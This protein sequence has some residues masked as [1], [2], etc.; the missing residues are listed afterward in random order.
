MRQKRYKT[1]ISWDLVTTSQSPDVPVFLPPAS[2]R[3]NDTEHDVTDIPQVP[4]L[5]LTS[6]KEDLLSEHASN[7]EAVQRHSAGT[8]KTPRTSNRP[9]GSV[10]TSSGD[11]G[12]KWSDVS[13]SNTGPRRFHFIKNSSYA[14]LHTIGPAY[15]VQKRRKSRRGD[16]PVFVEEA[17]ST[18]QRRIDPKTSTETGIE[19]RKDHVDS[20]PAAQI[21]EQRQ[22]KRPIVGAVEQKWRTE[23]W[24]K[25]TIA[26]RD[27]QGKSKTAQS[28]NE[29]SNQRDYNSEI[30]AA[31]LQQVATQETKIATANRKEARNAP[32]LKV[33][34]KPP[35]PRQP[36]VQ[37]HADAVGEDVSI[38]DTSEDGN[39]DDYVYDTY[40]RSAGPLADASGKAS[41]G[42]MGRLEC[43]DHSKIGI[44]IIAE[45]DQEEWDTFAEVDQDS[46]KDWNSEEEDENGSSNRQ[47]S[48]ICKDFTDL[49][50]GGFLRE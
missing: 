31:Q 34:P 14:S 15:R 45:E 17:V 42:D 30:L 32:Q 19:T 26:D 9:N 48:N 21:V 4:K 13:R 8:Q 3:L 6:P 2:T 10:L 11:P 1:E 46:D 49:N 27:I 41:E 12:Q 33:Q 22:R 44:L 7:L 38:M 50:S 43:I 29:P 25:S 16:L 36:I 5:R 35:K 24:A 18:S 47:W 39:E 28:I 37:Q 40:V 20:P 23:N